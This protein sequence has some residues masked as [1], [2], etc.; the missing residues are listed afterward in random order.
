M[1][2][3]RGPPPAPQ[4]AWETRCL[5]LIRPDPE[6]R[7]PSQAARETLKA[8]QGMSTDM[9]DGVPTSRPLPVHPAYIWKKDPHHEQHTET[10]KML[11]DL[12]SV[13]FF[14]R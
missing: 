1:P 12:V 13:C 14:G 11:H 7:S 9:Q 10:R 8:I 5:S 3:P 4:A 6:S 2:P